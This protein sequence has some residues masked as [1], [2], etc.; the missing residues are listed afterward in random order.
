MSLRI[1]A[2]GSPPS[3]AK[4]RRPD[5]SWYRSP[6]A[7]EWDAVVAKAVK[8]RKAPKGWLAVK[9]TVEQPDERGKLSCRIKLALDALTHCGFWDDDRTVASIVVK[10]GRKR[11]RRVIYE[12]REVKSK[13]KEK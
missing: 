11:D 12:V 10:Y 3:A 5:G 4:A 6:K 8:G 13:W 9:I 2:K 7:D 1:T